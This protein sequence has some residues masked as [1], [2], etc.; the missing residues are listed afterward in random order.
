MQHI[1]LVFL[2]F[3]SRNRKIF[4][5]LIIIK[6]LRKLCENLIVSC[7]KTSALNYFLENCSLRDKVDTEKKKFKV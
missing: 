3:L 6:N 7:Y 2:L 5:L 1:L 4:V